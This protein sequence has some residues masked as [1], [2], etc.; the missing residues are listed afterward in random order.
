VPLILPL[1]LLLQVGSPSEEFD[2]GSI[3]FGRAE[4]ARTIEILT[5]LLYPQPRLESEGAI[6]TAHRMLGVAHLFQRQN[7]QA[8]EEFRK[9]LQLR[10]DYRMDPLLDPPLVV[11]FFNNI[12]KQQEA[13]I[14]DLMR[15]RKEAEDEEA[16]RRRPPVIIERRLVR[17]SFALNF[18]PFGTGQFQNG[19]RGKGWFFLTT[20]SVLG[21]VSLGALTT[22][23]ALYGARPKIQCVP[24]PPGPNQPQ[25]DNDCSPGFVPTNAQDRSR[26]LLKVQMIS[27]AAFFA[28]AIWG[29]VDAVLHYREEVELP[30]VPVVPAARAPSGVRLG[31]QYFGDGGVG[32][33][34]TFRF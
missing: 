23:F 3:A 11:D 26:F 6:A 18:V 34:L 8:A 17:N 22:N 12:L 24:A 5:P 4:Y 7:A 31:L 33:G 15:K 25:G 21:A 10:P 29:V 30:G 1:L 19:Q 32:G 2:R 27:G 14:A 13:A 16:R 28:T 20:Q 9:L